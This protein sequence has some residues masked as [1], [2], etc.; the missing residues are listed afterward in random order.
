MAGKQHKQ[1][2]KSSAGGWTAVLIKVSYLLKAFWV[3]FPGVIFLGLGYFAFCSLGQGKDLLYQ[4]TDRGLTGLYMVLAATFWVFTSW[5]TARLVAYNR[6]DLYKVA[7]GWLYHLPRLL[8]YLIFWVLWL[9]ILAKDDPEGPSGW[10]TGGTFVLT[11]GLYLLL[12][13][14][15]DVAPHDVLSTTQLRIFRRLRR[16]VL[17]LM[18]VT[19]VAII[20]SWPARIFMVSLVALPLLQNGL[21]VLLVIRR[22]MA[23]ARGTA[24][25]SLSQLANRQQWVDQYMRWTLLDQ[26]EPIAKS[27]KATTHS[28]EE[29]DALPWDYE[30]PIFILYH[31]LAIV[32][33]LFYTLAVFYLPMA[34]SIS[35]FP[36]ALLSFGILLGV[37]NFLTLLSR[38]WRINLHFVFIVLVVLAGLWREP[39]HVRTAPGPNSYAQRPDLKTYTLWWLDKHKAAIESLPPNA[40]YPAL[41]VLADGGASRSGYWAAAVMDYLHRQ[42]LYDSAVGKSFFSHHLFCLS[43]ASGG[44][45]GNGSFVAQLAHERQH[46]T[47]PTHGAALDF[48]ANDFLSFALV[49]LLGPDVLMGLS[50]LPDR[51]YALEYGLEQPDSGKALQPLMQGDIGQLV[52]SPANELPALIINTTR[53]QDGAPAI[54]STLRL[55][56]GADSTDQRTDILSLLPT[57]RHLRLSTSVI[58]GARFPYMSPGGRIGQQYFVDGGYFDNSGAGAVHEIIQELHALRQTDTN[59]AL[60]NKVKFYVLHMANSPY[61]PETF[62]AIH[63]LVN[64]LATPLL[65]LAGSYSTQT[66]VN[67]SRLKY[68]LRNV[69]GMD[70]SY[71]YFNLY[72]KYV[73]DT[74]ESFPMNWVISHRRLDSMRQRVLDTDG[75]QQLAAN[76]R[77]RRTDVFYNIQEKNAADVRQVLDTTRVGPTL[78]LPEGYIEKRKGA[79]GV[80][81]E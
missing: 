64:N 57:D 73:K 31:L 66:T 45:V 34:R 7:P 54:I 3:F 38:R 72:K 79:T 43:G 15:L 46:G 39:H 23:R 63:P 71:K 33:L 59:Y 50:F 32:A 25:R 44:S 8:A 5:Y 53:V 56:H 78:L 35:S 75:L 30:R 10:L 68:E 20:I 22:P 19:I 80:S 76:L 81:R 41:F 58:L 48:L 67:D 14:Y 74:V 18:A 6:N 11:I 17:I 27:S 47:P 52:P 51:A 62:K 28:T 4:S 70:S 37:G 2:N 9:A 1:K 69:N 16:V 42:T 26:V 55:S 21:L 61:Q 36:L 12:H 60:L 13:R 77:A 49:R 65:T 24:L 29:E 40:S